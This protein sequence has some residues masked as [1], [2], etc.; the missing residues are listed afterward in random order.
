MRSVPKS[1]SFGEMA[2]S[3]S[4]GAP[5][6]VMAPMRLVKAPPNVGLTVKV[7]PLGPSE[8]SFECLDGFEFVGEAC[9][10]SRANAS[11]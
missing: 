11:S 6:D 3:S 8:P 5:P 2:S 1:R 10:R 9:W 4:S 7:P